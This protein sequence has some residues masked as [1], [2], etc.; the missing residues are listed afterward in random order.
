MRC[1]KLSHKRHGLLYTV[2]PSVVDLRFCAMLSHK[3]HGLL[4]LSSAEV[5]G[6]CQCNECKQYVWQNCMWAAP[7]APTL[8]CSYS[9]PVAL[10]WGTAIAGSL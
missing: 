3:K 1:H 4:Q 9:L 7:N 5:V 2:V 6:I 8:C 10:S